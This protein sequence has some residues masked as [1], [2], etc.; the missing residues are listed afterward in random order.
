MY[1]SEGAQAPDFVA[2]QGIYYPVDPNYAYYCTGIYIY[3]HYAISFFLLFE[4]SN[5]LEYSL[6]FRLWVA[7][8]MGEPSDVFWCGWFTSPVPGNQYKDFS[9]IV[10]SCSHS[11]LPSRVGRMKILP[12]Y[13]ILLVMDM[14]S[15][16]TIPSIL[17]S[18]ALILLSLLPNNSTLFLLTRPS[19]RR[20]MQLTLISSPVAQRTLW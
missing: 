4:L 20:P 14:H 5:N 6:L 15:L 8:R 12:I 10:G 7:R 11:P 2:D 1:T 18:P 3:L 13:T 17:T 19:H 9:F 16:L